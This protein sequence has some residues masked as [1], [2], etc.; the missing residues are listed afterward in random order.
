VA[1][2][3]GLSAACFVALF[4]SAQIDYVA[5]LSNHLLMALGV[6]YMLTW[7]II[8]GVFLRGVPRVGEPAREA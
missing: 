1:V 4:I 2:T 8:G 7:I 5:T 6:P 3:H